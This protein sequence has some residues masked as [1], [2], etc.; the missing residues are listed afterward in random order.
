MSKDCY[1]LNELDIINYLNEKSIYR[2]ICASSHFL[3]LS[4]IKGM[5]SLILAQNC[6]LERAKILFF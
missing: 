3:K 1:E 6:F 4:N 5:I 2:L